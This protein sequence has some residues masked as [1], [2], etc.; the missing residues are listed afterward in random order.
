MRLFEMVLDKDVDGIVAVSLVDKPAIE[1]NFIALSEQVEIQ[2][3]EVDEERGVVMGPVLIPNMRIKRRD[4]QGVFE[5]F[6]R[7]NR[8]KSS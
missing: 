6:F 8:I 2:L 3:K 5:I 7:A 1:E 4:E